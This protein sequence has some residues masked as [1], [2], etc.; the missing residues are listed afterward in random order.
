VGGSTESLLPTAHQFLNPGVVQQQIQSAE[1]NE[2]SDLD[3]EYA[4]TLTDPTPV[5]VLQTGD[6]VEGSG[7]RNRDECVSLMSALNL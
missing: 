5:T 4:M 7:I 6:L 1:Y 3:L 2:E